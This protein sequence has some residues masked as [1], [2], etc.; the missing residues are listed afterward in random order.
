MK[1]LP[2]LILSILTQVTCNSL[3]FAE[4]SVDD[5]LLLADEAIESPAMN[6]EGK[7]KKEKEKE[8]T[9]TFEEQPQAIAK[10]RKKTRTHELTPSE[11]LKL[12]RQ[13]LEERNR[14]MIEKKMEQIRYQQELALARQLQRSMNQTL[15]SIDNI[16]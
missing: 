2:L 15:K 3:A 16:E 9:S 10:P 12:V 13:R 8:V 5:E 1:L 7:Y 14:I 6:I 4:T 11:K